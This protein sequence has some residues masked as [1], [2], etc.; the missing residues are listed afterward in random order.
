VK[1]AITDETNVQATPKDTTEIHLVRPIKKEKLDWLLANRSITRITL[2]SSCLKRLPKKAQKKI[3]DKGIGIGVE[4][5]RGR[6]IDLPLE[7]IKEIIELRKDYQS[8]RDIERITDVPKST[9]HYLLKY[10]E[11]TK[12][13]K[14]N[15]IVYLK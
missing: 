7:K 10:A 15:T 2:S 14:G 4:K 1:C 13:K 9:I 8:I 3:K 11:R 6:A 5:R 12:I